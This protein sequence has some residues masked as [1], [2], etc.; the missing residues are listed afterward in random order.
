VAPRQLGPLR[1][2]DLVFKG[3]GA[4]SYQRVVLLDTDLLLLNVESPS[5]HDEAAW[6]LA[7][8]FFDSLQVDSK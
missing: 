1:A 5:E 4:V 7:G 2:V 6:K 3:P 8:T